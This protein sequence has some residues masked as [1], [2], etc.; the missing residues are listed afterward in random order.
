MVERVHW[1]LRIYTSEGNLPHFYCLTASNS[2]CSR[3]GTTNCWVPL[4]Y[5]SYFLLNRSIPSFENASY[6]WIVH[7]IA[8]FFSRSSEKDDN[9]GGRSSLS[10]ETSLDQDETDRVKNFFS[11]FHQIVGRN[12]LLVMLDG[13]VRAILDISKKFMQYQIGEKR[14]CQGRRGLK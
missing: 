13:Y 5:I 4:T 9:V 11:T 2:R 3:I 8:K 14:T 6:R 7:G 12:T 10:G 1:R